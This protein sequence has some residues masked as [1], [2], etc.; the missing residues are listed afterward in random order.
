[1]IDVNKIAKRLAPYFSIT[2]G[3]LLIAVSLFYA[4][5]NL[6]DLSLQNVW[7]NNTINVVSQTSRFEL[8]AKDMQSN[9]RGYLLTGDEAVLSDMGGRGQLV[10]ISDTLFNLL[11]ND[12]PQKARVIRMM[13]ITARIVAFNQAVVDSFNVYG[14]ESASRLIKSGEGMFLFRQL[15]DQ[16]SEIDAYAGT[17]LALGQQRADENRQRAT[18]YI[19]LT[20][21]AGLGITLLALYFLFWD[22]KKQLA[23]KLQI[24]Q[25]ERLLNQYLE[26]I[27][28]GIIVIDPDRR[29]TFINAAGRAMLGLARGRPIRSLGDIAEEIPLLDPTRMGERFD[30]DNLPISRGLRGRRSTGNRIDIDRGGVVIKGETSVEPIYALEGGIVGA[31]S[32]FRDITEREAHALNLKTA[33]DLAQ[34]S[35]RARDVFLSNVS[36]EIRTPLNA[37]LGF[38]NWLEK[39]VEDG[40]TREYIGYIQIASLNLLELINDLLDISKIEADQVAL[41]LG[42]TSISALVESVGILIRQKATDKGIAYQQ[43]LS[44]DLPGII[45]TDKTRLTQILLNLCGNAVKFTNVGYVKVAVDSLGQTGGDTQRIRFTITDTGIGIPADKQEQIFDRFVQASDSTS[46]R[47]GGTGLGLS[48]SKALVKLMEGEL[49]LESGVGRGTKFT[50]EFDFAVLEDSVEAEPDDPSL[51]GRGRLAELSILAAEDN[52]LNQKLLRAIFDRVGSSLTIVGNGLKAVER[53]KRES[54][55][56]IIM[57]VQMPVMDGYAAIREIRNTLRLATPIITMT[58]HAMVGEKE[59]GIRIGADSYISKPYREAELFREIISLT[60]GGRP[61][62]LAEGERPGGRPSAAPLLVDSDYLREVTAGDASLRAELIDLFEEE[63]G[64]QCGAIS[65][66]LDGGDH[67]ALRK[68]V[69]ALRSSLFSVALLSLAARYKEVETALVSRAIPE[70]L[71]QT[72]A[73]LEAELSAGLRELRAGELGPAP[74]HLNPYL[75]P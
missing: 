15:G 12:R 27:P 53:L 72:L 73:E 58:A 46:S 43:E 57:D 52:V 17:Q 19:I 68:A 42:P 21:I 71:A 22:R 38:T 48:I 51:S 56:I 75:N 49:R 60:Q 55:D 10:A 69:H 70:D 74:N 35:V 50:L 5:K 14:R 18:L 61:P 33:R 66:A 59:E 28:D 34:Q 20:G 1:M 11:E 26:A 2:S 6:R 40:K 65:E 8:V 16:V 44:D 9:V 37:I 54:F 36:H 4:Y 63:S 32:I 31:I 13:A 30:T 39:E 41:D 24:Y 23:L 62:G 7:V 29:V 3:M 47:Y 45:V 25:K 67:E 64:R